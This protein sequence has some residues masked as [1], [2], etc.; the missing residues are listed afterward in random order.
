MSTTTEIT[1]REIIISRILNAPQVLVFEVWTKPEH[2]AHW[3]GPNGF[4][5]TTED[6]DIKAGGRWKFTMHG[7]GM[8][9]PTEIVYHE[10]TPITKLRYAVSGKDHP[11]HLNFTTTVTFENAGEGKT[12]VT[13]AGLFQSKEAVEFVLRE[14]GAKKGGEETIGKLAAYVEQLAQ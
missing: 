5:V 13:M 7:H 1:D 6:A 11:E 4:S 9:F 3:W 2:L 14:H 8:E 12:K 10:V